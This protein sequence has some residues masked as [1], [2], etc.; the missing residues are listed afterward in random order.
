MLS[1][2]RTAQSL[3]PEC[4]D[5]SSN[6]DARRDEND[7]VKFAISCVLLSKCCYIVLNYYNRPIHNDIWWHIN[8]KYFVTYYAAKPFNILFKRCSVEF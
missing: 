2:S 1:E 3:K 6:C 5:I 7:P 8:D 4:A